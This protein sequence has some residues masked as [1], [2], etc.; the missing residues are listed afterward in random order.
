MLDA[1]FTNSAPDAATVMSVAHIERD[2]VEQAK[3]Y[4]TEMR[5]VRV[6]ALCDSARA[7][8]SRL[9]GDS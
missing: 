6:H 4:M 1:Q 9:Y 8:P 2:A 5:V 7:P 3:Y